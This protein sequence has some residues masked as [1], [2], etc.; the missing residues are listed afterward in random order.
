MI[1]FHIFV[2]IN[3]MSMK[4]GTV[5]TI[6]IEDFKANS[7]IIDYVDDDFVVINSLENLPNS[8]DTVRSVVH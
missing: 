1:I 5:T 2:V 4:K 6:G 7:H 3:N 8:N